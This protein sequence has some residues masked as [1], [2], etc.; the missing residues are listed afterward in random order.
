MALFQ[1]DFMQRAIF[2]C[3]AIAMFAP[4]LG[5]FLILRG[6]ALMAD[7]LSHVSLAGVALG[8][9]LGLNPTWTTM[10]FVVLAA[11]LLEYLRHVYENY[12]DI[13]IAM[14]MSGGM[15]VALL[16][17]SRVESAASIESFLFGSIVAVSPLQVLLL[18]VL[19]VLVLALYWRFRRMLYVLAFDE[20]TAFTAGLPTRALSIGFS[21]LTGLAISV[22]MPIAGAL[23][24][25]AILIMPAAI[26][27]RSMKTFNGVLLFAGALGLIGMLSGLALSFYWGTPPGATIAM[28][29]VLAFVVQAVLLKIRGRH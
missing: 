21:L 19:A 11:L 7:T 4:I 8:Y 15:A 2:A 12:S 9:L 16:L 27:M 25:S 26:G 13:S 3:L 20:D 5:L 18:W 14:L 10:A 6:Q 1:Y 23:L 24:V 22:V 28:L 29:F 17:L